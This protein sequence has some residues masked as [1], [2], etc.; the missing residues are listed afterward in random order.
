MSA[1]FMQRH[2][3][4]NQ[5]GYIVLLM[6]VV[7]AAVATMIVGTMTFISTR[8]VQSDYVNVSANQARLAADGCVEY[9]LQEITNNDTYT[10]TNQVETISGESCT[11]SVL[12]TGGTTR[13]IQSI[14][15]VQGATVRA[16]VSLDQVSPIPNVVVWEYVDAL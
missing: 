10:V 14:S 1:Y 3:L 2:H 4:D 16:R 12:D 9:A 15:D 6:V 7:I 8:L 13:E 5:H 11:Y